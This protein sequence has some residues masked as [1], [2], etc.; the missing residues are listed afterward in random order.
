MTAKPTEAELEILAVI[1]DK[2]DATVRQVHDELSK[3]R[4]VGYTTV[5]KLMQIMA[6][7]GLVVRDTSQRS[8]VYRPADS[9]GRTRRK[10][11]RDLIE[12]AFDGSASK[13]V[14][15]V[16]TSKR[17]SPK[18]LAELRAMLD[19]IERGKR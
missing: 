3:R 8:H 12:R 16:L 19:D 18:E 7:K 17:S 9:A 14:M 6:D 4:D 13:L 1:W 10:L 15:E 11:V 5:L 2:G